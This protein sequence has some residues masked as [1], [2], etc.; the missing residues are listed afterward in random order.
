MTKQNPGFC[1]VKL[2]NMKYESME[3]ND[4]SSDSQEVCQA[5]SSAKFKRYKFKTKTCKQ[6][7]G[8]N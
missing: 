6:E 8:K 2:M 4:H 7:K 1:T 3:S 5:K